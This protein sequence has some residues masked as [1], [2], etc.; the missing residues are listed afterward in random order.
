MGLNTAKVSKIGPWSCRACLR[1]RKE[2]SVKQKDQ[3]REP[4]RK[5]KETFKILQWNGN[6][7]R[8][9]EK[10]EDLRIPI[11][12]TECD[13]AIGSRNPPFSENKT[14]KL[15]GYKEYKK[16]RKKGRSRETLKGEGV[17]TLVKEGLQHRPLKE[18][19]TVANDD[20]TNVQGISVKGAVQDLKCINLYIPPIREDSNAKLL[21]P[22]TPSGRCHDYSRRCKRPQPI[23]G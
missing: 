14:P 1:N 13:I 19:M 20:T 10:V 23:L 21:T 4:K 3:E 5:G 8:S 11:Q 22:K 12:R 2:E 7:I 16:D 18:N 9:P 17:M 15:K 6:G